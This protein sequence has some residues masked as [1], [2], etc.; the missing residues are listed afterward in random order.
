MTNTYVSFISDKLQSEVRIWI[1]IF[2]T[3]VVIKMCLAQEQPS[4]CIVH[5]LYTQFQWNS[6]HLTMCRRQLLGI[7]FTQ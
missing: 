4:M 3:E 5:E 6:M 1:S 2:D 7:L